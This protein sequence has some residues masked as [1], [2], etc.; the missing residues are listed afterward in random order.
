[1]STLVL[2]PADAE[3]PLQ[4]FRP[5]QFAWLRV[6]G[7]WGRCQP[8]P[9]SVAPVDAAPGALHLAVPHSG[10]VTSVM[11]ALQPG[12]KVFVDG[13]YDAVDDAVPH[14]PGL[15]LIASA[16]IISRRALSG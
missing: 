15:L 4:P 8:M 6:D 7:A 2:V 13:P 3:Q 14:Q 10:D 9:F 5:G 16:T 1:M 11:G 12:R